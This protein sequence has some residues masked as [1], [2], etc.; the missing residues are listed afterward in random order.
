ME[1]REFELS[2]VCDVR[3]NLGYNAGRRSFIDYF[4]G[5]KKKMHGLVF[6]S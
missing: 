1:R 5:L 2:V 3:D 6:F 4:K